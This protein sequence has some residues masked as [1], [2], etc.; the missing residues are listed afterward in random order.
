MTLTIT[1]SV[2]ELLAV[3]TLVG[4]DAVPGVAPDTLS[5][6][7]RGMDSDRAVATLLDAGIVD[8][9]GLVAPFDLLFT[10]VFEP[11]M[12][13]SH[14]RMS[15]NAVET[16]LFYVTPAVAVEQRALEGTARYEFSAFDSDDFVSRLAEVSGLAASPG[17]EVESGVQ[18][19]LSAQA[20]DAAIR[21]RS[22][23][24]SEQ[25][26]LAPILGRANAADL[27]SNAVAHEISLVY[28]ADET[29]H[30]SSLAWLD[31]LGL[32]RWRIAREESQAVLLTFATRKAIGYTVLALLP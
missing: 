22:E 31:G 3:A 19:T 6:D 15:G 30:A 17:E 27:V 12:V 1:A 29:T 13:I 20:L 4:S 2:E 5:D 18:L 10:V 16:C 21:G 11:A 32:G 26:L 23:A 7:L 25:L 14:T 9:S 28:V 24:L 8:G